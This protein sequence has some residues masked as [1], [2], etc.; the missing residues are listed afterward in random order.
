MDVLDV[1]EF[2]YEIIGVKKLERAQNHVLR[3]LNY[4]VHFIIQSLYYTISIYFIYFLICINVFSCLLP[5]ELEATTFSIIRR[6]FS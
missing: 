4:K 2:I 5:V 3:Y 6:G 1:V